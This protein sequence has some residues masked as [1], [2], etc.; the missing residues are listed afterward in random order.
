MCCIASIRSLSR[1]RPCL[2]FF[3]LFARVKDD[4][5]A[6]LGIPVDLADIDALGPV[7]KKYILPEAVYVTA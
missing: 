3:G 2:E 6:A 1:N 5:E 7:G 4:L